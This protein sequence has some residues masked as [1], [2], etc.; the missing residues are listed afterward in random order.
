V[1]PL[2]HSGP[3]IRTLSVTL[4]LLQVAPPSALAEW[5]PA[6]ET[7][8]SPAPADARPP[9][10]L[11]SVNRAAPEGPAPS[12]APRFSRTATEAEIFSARVFEE[13]LVPTGSPT[14]AAEN[15]ALARALAA[16]QQAGVPEATGPFLDF[17]AKFPRSAWRGSLLMNLGLVYRR[18]GYFSRALDAFEEAWALT[19]ESAR[20][21]ATADRAV[22]QLAELNG[23]LGRRE[24]LDALFAEIAGRD[25]GGSAGEV[26][27]RVREGRAMMEHDPGIAFRCGPHALESIY[28]SLHPNRRKPDVLKDARSTREGTSLLQMRNLAREAGLNL[29]AARRDPGARLPLPALVH[30]KTQHFAALLE[31]S[32]GRYRAK[33]P[34]FGGEFWVSVAALD[35]EASGVFLVPQGDLPEGWSA[36]DTAAAAGVWGKGFVDT[37]EPLTPEEPKSCPV[38]EDPLAMASYTFNL[39]NISLKIF[40]APVGYDPPVGPPVRLR[41]DYNQRDTFQP[42]TFT[43]SNLGPKWTLGWLSYL[44]DDPSNTAA[45]V[46]LYARSGGRTTYTGMGD[47]TSDIDRRNQ[48]VLVRTGTSPIRYERRLPDGSVEVFSLATGTAPRKVFMTHYLDPQGNGLTFS[49]DGSVRLTQVTDAIGQ[50]TTLH[51]EGAD[52]LKITK[53]TDPFGRAATFEYSGGRLSRITDVIGITSSFNY[54]S[55]DFLTAL[56]TPY[57]VTSFSMSQAPESPPSNAIRRTLEA[58]D[59]MGGKERAE[60]YQLAPYTTMNDTPPEGMLTTTQYFAMRNTY[61]WDKRAMAL[62]PGDYTK[63]HIYHWLH[64]QD[65]TPIGMAVLESERSALEGRVFYNYPG[66]GDPWDEGTMAR[67]SAIGRRLDDGTS[68]IRRFEY[69]LLGKVI[70]AVDPRGRETRYTY[71]TNNTPDPVPA[72]GTSIDLLKIEQ[73]TGPTTYDTLASITYN[74]QHRPLTVIDAAGQT[75]TYTYNAAGQVLTMTTP[76]RAGITENRTTTYSYDAQGYLLRIDGPVG[77]ALT[78]Y[79]YDGHG[80]VRTVSDADGYTRV[81]DYDALDRP[82]RVTYPDNTYEETTYERLDPVGHRDRLGRVSQTRYD[83]LR[84]P[85]SMRDPLGRTITQQWCTC[86]SLD[87]L[88][89]AKGNAT[90]WTRDLLGRVEIEKRADDRTWEYLYETMSGRLKQRKDGKL[91]LT[92]YEYFLDDTLKQVSYAAV[93]IPTPTVSYS[94]DLVYEQLLTRTDGAGLTNYAYHPPLTLG[95][96][97]LASVDGPLSGDTVTYTYDELGRLATRGLAGFT[98]TLSYDSLGRLT[99]TASPLGP[100]AYAYDGP[101]SRPLALAYPNGQSTQY[102]YFPNSGDHRLQRIKHLAPGGATISQYDYTY[103]PVGNIATWIQQVGAAAPKSYTFGYDAADQLTSATVTGAPPLPVPSRYAYDYDMAGNRIAE[104]LDN[105]VSGAAFNSRNQLASRQPG[106]SLLFRG[107][108][109]E[110]AKVTVQGTPAP[111]AGNNTFTGHA[112]AAG[113]TTTDVAVVATDGTGGARTNT[114]R[115]TQGS[116]STTTYTYDFNGNLVG[117]GTRT[118]EWDAENRL[119][120]VKQGAATLASF[121]YDGAGRRVQK[122]AAG[123]TTTYAYDGDGVI[124]ERRSP[125]TTLRYVRGPVIDQH[126]GMRNCAGTDTYFLADH[127]G[128]VVQ[129]TNASGT[130]T[131]TRDYDAYGN[132]L[133]GSGQSGYA[134]TGREWDSEIGL[135]YYRARYYDPRIGRF[136]N[137]DPIGLAGGINF[138]RYVAANPA[139]LTDPTGLQVPAPPVDPVTITYDVVI[140]VFF[141][142]GLYETSKGATAMASPSPTPPLLPPSTMPPARGRRKDNDPYRVPRTNDPGR[143]QETGNCKPCPPDGPYWEHQGTPG[144]HGCPSGTH[145]HNVVWRQDPATCICYSDRADYTTRPY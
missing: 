53:V 6:P 57:G 50:V 31:E 105:D 74:T 79:T 67:P 43:Y 18:T 2:R 4:A 143:C 90:T 96:G 24:R 102:T 124:E 17:L 133:A 54:G 61:Y 92:N 125:G 29:Q 69:N 28:T 145:W 123:V 78:I 30:W 141:L 134:Y 85:I 16:Y 122:V 95:A 42:M 75:M 35:A 99:T 110:P 127:L 5:I 101:T 80:R 86:G 11:V 118:Y 94:Y 25:V 81:H 14:S 68:Q 46:S 121:A 39:L 62:G 12:L 109:N 119:I 132:P 13:P 8:K 104:Q 64:P 129:T 41:V 65:G 87:K 58:T 9:A 135:Y 114:Y 23:R 63:A 49:F 47:A 126:W 72:T 37:L 15:N 70:K 45:P 140:G 32:G 3:A 98:S 115:V 128:S 71:G 142:W 89:D 52:P 91:Q 93:A 66:Q 38:P 144:A 82:T 55:G 60:F 117:D 139:N 7:T 44:E 59:P 48:S 1:R 33:D 137:E 20:S 113:A 112:Q 88:V 106:G 36:I 83:P 130:V 103:T 76:P 84:R 40:D 77:G 107:S 56:T 138:Y 22:A 100:F 116:G 34:T 51:Y 111:V 120:A 73:K 21:K 108:L 26:L 131:L 136:L 10:P 27:V 19:R 97:Q